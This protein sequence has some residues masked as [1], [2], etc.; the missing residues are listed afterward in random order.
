MDS[1]YL[2]S[3]PSNEAEIDCVLRKRVTFNVGRLFVQVRVSGL[4]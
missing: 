3:G 2:P 1:I 4:R